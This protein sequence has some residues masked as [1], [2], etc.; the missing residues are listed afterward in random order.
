MH[1]NITEAIASQA[2]IVAGYHTYPH[3]DM[4]STAVRAAK[5]L[6]SALDGD[7]K[8]TMVWGKRPHTAPRD[9]PG[10]RRLSQRSVA[11]ARG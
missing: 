7:T 6:F 8:P 9:A 4:D 2:T 3:I 5:V 10:N 1:A 11:T